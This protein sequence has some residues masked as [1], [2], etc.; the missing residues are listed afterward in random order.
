MRNRGLGVPL[1]FLLSFSLAHGG[2]GVACAA[3]TATAPETTAVENVQPKQVYDAHESYV[4]YHLSFASSS[5]KVS[6]RAPRSNLTV[7]PNLLR[8][9]A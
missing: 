8:H 4:K 3:E 6:L 5:T 1:L 7:H 2:A 9:L